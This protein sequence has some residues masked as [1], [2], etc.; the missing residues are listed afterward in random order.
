MFIIKSVHLISVH[1]WTY[2]GDGQGRL[3]V[4]PVGLYAAALWLCNQR[5][6]VEVIALSKAEAHLG[7]KCV[8]MAVDSGFSVEP[9]GRPQICFLKCCLLELML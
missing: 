9:L 6:K 7:Q 8:A 4:V 1:F 2:L 3:H 5:K